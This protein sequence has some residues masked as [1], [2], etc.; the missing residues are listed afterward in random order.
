MTDL[1]LGIIGIG[2]MG[3][4][5]AVAVANGKVEGMRLTAVCDINEAKTASF[6]REYEHVAAFADY[7][8]L[9]DS[10]VCD[11]VLIAVPHKDHAHIAIDALNAGMHTLV[12]KP[13][14][15]TVSAA[16]RLNAAAEQSGKV[17]GIMFNQRTN[18]LF[19]KAREIVKGGALG[20]L[21]RTV[22]TITNWYRSERYYRSGDWRATWSGE[23]GGVLLNQAPHQLDLWQW[24]CG[25]PVS[26]TAFCDVAKFHEVEVEDDATVFTRY[27]NGAT[28]TFIT[29][30]GEYPGTNRLEIAGTRGKLVLQDGILKWWRLAEDER[31][32]CKN[33]EKSCPSIPFEI[34]EFKQ[35]RAES[36]HL[37]ILQNFT[38]AVLYGEPLLADGTEGIRELTLSNA[39]YLS[40]WTGNRTVELPFDDAA[41]DRLLSEKAAASTASKT[42]HP[43]QPVNAYKSR[44]QVNW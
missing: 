31:D 15:I 11:A 35:E 19:Q 25:M 21:K 23:G 43:E 22:W 18:P 6:C 12:E 29:S 14:D 26:V 16:K 20:E 30:T 1:K 10:G 36:G 8:D 13:V 34:E 28:G 40:A 7:H 2:N 17:F 38:N 39:A 3:R 41:F 32:V 4:A 24:I 37:G 33:S 27:A 9:L 5:H 42:P 44:W